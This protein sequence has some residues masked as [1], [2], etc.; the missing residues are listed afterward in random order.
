M[1]KQGFTLIE[2]LVVITIIAL[3]VSILMPALNKARAQAKDIVCRSNQ[4]QIAKAIAVF[5]AS[6]NDKLFAFDYGEKF[7]FRKIAKILGEKTYSNNPNASGDGGVAE[8]GICPMTKIVHLEANETISEPAWNETWAMATNEYLPNTT[9]PTT[10]EVVGSYGINC[11]LLEDPARSYAPYSGR[12]IYQYWSGTTIDR[13]KYYSPYSQA[14]G[15]VPLVFDSFRMDAWPEDVGVRP[16]IAGVTDQTKQYTTDSAPADSFKRICVDRH[17]KAINMG[18]VDGHV[19]KVMLEE[20]WSF[21][22]NK[23]FRIQTTMK[24]Y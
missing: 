6:N 5:A 4:G 11:W 3:L 7:W 2:L 9:T 19:D 8:L 16:V 24:I 18:F 13:T 15:D 23:K 21:K 10:G 14:K 22:W 20:L 12:S 17:G 1:K